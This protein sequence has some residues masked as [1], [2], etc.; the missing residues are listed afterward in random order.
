MQTEAQPLSYHI[1]ST[2]PCCGICWSTT[3]VPDIRMLQ[4]RLVN[5]DIPTMSLSI[6][7]LC[8]C[9]FLVELSISSKWLFDN[10]T[11]FP[12]EF[13][14]WELL[15]QSPA[16]LLQLVWWFARTDEKSFAMASPNFSNS[17]L[18]HLTWS[19]AWGLFALGGPWQALTTFSPQLKTAACAKVG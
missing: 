1:I 8:H 10:S 17:C 2:I 4:Q 3:T 19:L 5:Q 9:R 13:S 14:S 15:E 16:F 18:P 7:V 12:V 6:S 11:I